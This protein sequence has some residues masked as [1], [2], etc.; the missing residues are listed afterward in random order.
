MIKRPMLALAVAWICGLL[1]AKWQL[2]FGKSIFILIYFILMSIVIL[3]LN[4]EPRWLNSYVHEKRYPQMTIFF[5]CIPF[6][7]FIGYERME[8]MQHK[9][10]QEKEAWNELVVAGEAYVFVEGIIKEKYKEEDGIRLVLQQCLIKGYEGQES[11]IAGGCQIT[12][13]EESI[14]TLIGNKIKVYGKVFIYQKATNEGQ[15]D[16][17]EYYSAKRIYASIKALRLEILDGN[18]SLI[19]QNMFLL[20]QK[21]RES[22]LSLYPKEKAGVLSAMLLGDKDLLE[23][24]I[25]QLYQKNGISHILAISGL[26]ISMLC[27]GLFRLLR[28]IGVSVKLSISITILFLSFYVCYTGGSTSSLRAGVMC[29]VLLGAKLVRRNYD[30][31]SALALASIL[32]TAIRPTEITSAGFLLSFGAVIGVAIAKGI[33]EQIVQKREDLASNLEKEIVEDKEVIEDFDKYFVINK[34]RKLKKYWKKRKESGSIWWSPLLFSGMIQVIT[35]PISLWFYY[36]LSPY[37]ILL[38]VIILPLVA[39]ILG[40][41]IVSVLLGLVMPS[42]AKLSVGGTYFLLDFYEWLGEHTL[43][44]PYSFVLVGRP[45]ILQIM[46]YYGIWLFVVWSIFSIEKKKQKVILEQEAVKKSLYVKRIV[47]CIGIIVSVSILLFF[48][49]YEMELIFLDVSQGDA[50]FLQ[51][52]TGK[53]L[54]F[55]CGSSD[56]SKVGT[57][58]LTPMLKQRG[59]LLVDIVSVSHIDSD[60][61]NGIKEL[62]EEMPVYEGEE[63]FRGNYKGAIGIKTVVLPKILEPSEEY[64]ALVQLAR[65]KNVE[66]VYME[67]GETLYQADGILIEC[68]S[69]SNAKQSENDTSLVYLLQMK[70]IVVWMMGDAGIEVEQEIIERIGKKT[71]EQLKDRFCVLKVGHHGS[72]TSSSEEFVKMIEP[73]VAIISCGY[74][75]RYGHPHSQVLEVFREVESEIWRTDLQGAIKIRRRKRAWEISSSPIGREKVE[76]R[77]V[78]RKK[79]ARLEVKK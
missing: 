7:F 32:V 58:R 46:L 68:L 28:R 43:K 30:L 26:H 4:K 78:S 37:S 69:P 35:I 2:P 40:G 16:A 51:T 24:E 66:I 60:H 22:L 44:L 75:N 77:G 33:E 42:L 59:I 14:N 19:G 74:Q 34:F 27:M 21:M 67:A 76:K 52:K 72:K 45:S 47:L 79:V 55:D 15:F 12:L 23:E 49:T 57:Y 61:I 50:M 8:Y 9:I 39:F 54:L 48:K 65:E 71:L 6:L 11:A 1:I 31:L 53:T 73:E 5:L 38:N 56:V 62:L 10:L 63:E 17:F 29:I 13:E 70:D 25:K 20:K 36:E 41:G 64:L 3:K 18:I